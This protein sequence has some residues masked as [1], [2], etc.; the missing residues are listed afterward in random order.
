[1]Q[2]NAL[3]IRMDFVVELLNNLKDINLQLSQVVNNMETGSASFFEQ[4]LVENKIGVQDEI[5]KYKLNIERIKQLNTEIVV[6]INSWYDFLKQPC[7]IKKISFP[8]TFYIRRKKLRKDLKEMNSQ[9]S[10]LIIDNRFIKEHLTA[11][12][13]EFMCNAIDSLKQGDNYKSYEDLSTKRKMIL[14]EIKYLLES[15]PQ[16]LQI[17]LDLSEINDFIEKISKLAAA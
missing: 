9:I 11:W 13:H 6:K 12:E 5:K 17:E 15:Y 14:S 2:N 7:K 1:M 4:F 10:S 8:I 16:I 3:K